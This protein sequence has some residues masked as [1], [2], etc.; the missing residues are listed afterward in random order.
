MKQIK[1]GE[2]LVVSISLVILLFPCII[3]VIYDLKNEYLI[4]TIVDIS[5]STVMLIASLL[6]FLSYAGT[7]FNEKYLDW[8]RKFW[9]CLKELLWVPIPSIS[10]DKKSLRVHVT[11]LY[12]WFL[13]WWGNLYYL[14]NKLGVDTFHFDKQTDNDYFSLIDGI[15]FSFITAFT[16]GYG[17]FAPA[18]IYGKIAVILEISINF[19]FLLTLLQK[20]YS[21]D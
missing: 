8:G 6:F 12:F 20:I 15:Y 3:Y 13:I 18:S 17:D 14:L 21:E 2:Y 4:P 7:V 11:R 19:L 16:I 10:S 5:I 1:F 9:D